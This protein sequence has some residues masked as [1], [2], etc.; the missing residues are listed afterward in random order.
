MTREE[1]YISMKGQGTLD[2]EL[3]INT[4]KLLD[5][6]KDYGQLCNNDELQFQ[7]VHQVEEL[8]MKLIA[9]TFLELEEHMQ[10]KNT[11]KALTLFDRVHRLMELMIQQLELLETMSPKDYQTIRLQLGNGSGQE[12][13]GFNTLLKLPH[14]IWNVFNNKY[15]LEENLTVEKIYDSEYSH[16]DAY[17]IAEAMIEFDELFLK[18]RY[19]HICLI[20]RS[21]GISAKSLKGRSV[22]ILHK[23]LSHQFYPALW[24]IRSDMTDTWGG[25][26]GQV[27]D[28]ISK[29]QKEKPQHV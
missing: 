15:L 22:D 19:Y 5:C 4:P 21:I 14:N 3:Y 29:S 11:R 2:Y 28:S 17:M 16:C 6:Q 9:F 7:I 8:W 20:N 18:F 13:P 23:G 10:T 26:Y 12:S 1:A 24:K 25:E 27:R